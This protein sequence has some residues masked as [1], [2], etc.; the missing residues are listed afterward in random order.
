MNFGRTMVKK[1]IQKKSRR[2]KRALKHFKEEYADVDG[3]QAI[4]YAP[5]VF[6]GIVGVIA[7]IAPHLIPV[8]L[9]S[10]FLFVGVLLGVAAWKF[11]QLKRKFDHIVKEFDGRI[12]I[13]GLSVRDSF[14]EQDSSEG[15]KIIY[16]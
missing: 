2:V 11:L 8:L 15:K 16:H 3:S 12:M 9:S 5:A 13:Q 6:F 10:V 14:D 7:L 1:R 4:M